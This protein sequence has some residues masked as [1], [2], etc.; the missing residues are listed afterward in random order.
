MTAVNVPASYSVSKCFQELN[1]ISKADYKMQR[2]R[3]TV[4]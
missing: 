3:V 1:T 4:S 2:N